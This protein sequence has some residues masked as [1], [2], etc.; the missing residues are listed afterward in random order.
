MLKRNADAGSP[1]A[2]ALTAFATV[3]M[4]LLVSIV[5]FVVTP[6]PLT[7]QEQIDIRSLAGMWKGTLSNGGSFTWTIRE[8]GTYDADSQAPTGQL[9]LSSGRISVEGGRLRFRSNIAGRSGSLTLENQGAEQVIK[10]RFDQ[11]TA[12]FEVRRTITGVA[13]TQIDDVQARSS[14][15]GQPQ[16]VWGGEDVEHCFLSTVMGQVPSAVDLTD[17]VISRR[18]LA[19]G[20]IY[21]LSKCPRGAGGYFSVR[22]VS[23]RYTAEVYGQWTGRG[24][25]ELVNYRNGPA[26]EKGQAE[27]QARQRARAAEEERQARLAET[28]ARQVASAEAGGPALEAKRYWDRRLTGCGDYAWA[29]VVGGTAQFKSF[30]YEITPLSLSD[31]DKTL[32]KIEWRIRTNIKTGTAYRVWN[33]F[34]ERWVTDWRGFDAMDPL[35]PMGTVIEKRDGTIYGGASSVNVKVLDC[36]TLPR[37]S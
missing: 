36:A 3:G 5:C 15:T 9:N 10:G 25:T 19:D 6:W 29:S 27:A 28:A 34:Y 22:L 26:M 17:D 31:I 35:M 7:A 12:G 8:D 24:Y 20:K 21:L 1:D 37:G 14:G 30:A 33:P 32:N 16:V 23:P 2:V 13:G 18:L 11:A 4:Y